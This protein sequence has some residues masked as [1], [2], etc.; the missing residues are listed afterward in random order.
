ML[1]STR[2]HPF[3]S[4]EGLWVAVTTTSRSQAVPLGSDDFRSGELLKTSYANPWNLTTIKTADMGP[5]EGRLEE[6][7]LTRSRPKLLPTSVSMSTDGVGH[8]FA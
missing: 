8:S 6:G 2:D 4:E 5:V 1:V 3:E 7:V